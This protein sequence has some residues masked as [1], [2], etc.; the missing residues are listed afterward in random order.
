MENNEN[1]CRELNDQELESA[2]GGI[3]KEFSK[4]YLCKDCGAVSF[5]APANNKCPKCGGDVVLQQRR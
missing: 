4:R 3:S 5:S 1:K 2:V